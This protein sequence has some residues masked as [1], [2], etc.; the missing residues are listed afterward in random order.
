MFFNPDDVKWFQ[1]AQLT[2]KHGL[3]GNIVE[4]VGEHGTMKCLFNKGVQQHDTICL[5]LYKRV[6]P[7]YVDKEGDGDDLLVL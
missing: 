7:K 5:V 4:S 2:T 3:V 6:Y 1:P